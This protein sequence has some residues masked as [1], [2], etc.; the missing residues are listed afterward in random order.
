LAS[1]AVGVCV[2]SKATQIGEKRKIT[3]ITPFKVIQGH[4]DH[5]QSKAGIRLPISD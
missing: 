4:G 2:H 3:A 1:V 5:Y